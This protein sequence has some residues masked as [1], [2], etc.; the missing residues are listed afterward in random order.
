M[1]GTV[2]DMLHEMKGISKELTEREGRRYAK[3]SPGFE[4]EP[5]KADLGEGPETIHPQDY[6]K[7]HESE[8]KQ[9]LAEL[10]R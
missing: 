2:R 1:A 4:H 3:A 8:D 5:M 10:E 9:S 7:L 6:S